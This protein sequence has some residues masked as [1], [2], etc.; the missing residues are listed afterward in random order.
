[1][2]KGRSTCIHN[3]RLGSRN[4]LGTKFLLGRQ[5]VIGDKLVLLTIRGCGGIFIAGR[6]K[7]PLFTIGGVCVKF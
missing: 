2:H 4:K 3:M 7:L 1:M 6:G 5:L